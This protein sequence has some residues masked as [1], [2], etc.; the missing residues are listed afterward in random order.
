MSEKL[1][2]LKV[3]VDVMEFVK[4]ASGKNVNPEILAAGFEGLT[5]EESIEFQKHLECCIQ[6]LMTGRLRTAYG[7]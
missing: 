3:A 2:L 1:E 6:L 4:F 7:R 5:Q